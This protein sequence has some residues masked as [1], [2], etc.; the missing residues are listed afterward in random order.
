MLSESLLGSN[1][2]KKPLIYTHYSIQ[3]VLGAHVKVMGSGHDMCEG[4]QWKSP[5][6]VCQGATQTAMNKTQAVCTL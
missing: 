6:L 2:V 5:E 1:A 3:H 4:V